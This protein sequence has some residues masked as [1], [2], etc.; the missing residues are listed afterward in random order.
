MKTSSSTN[1][2]NKRHAFT[3]NI[4]NTDSNM[5]H[6]LKACT[7]RI[8]S[9]EYKLQS[10]LNPNNLTFTESEMGPGPSSKSINFPRE[11]PTIIFHHVPF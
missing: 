2:R 9:G 3:Q 11:L 6:G 7:F 10:L 4:L 8:N 5:L 1:S